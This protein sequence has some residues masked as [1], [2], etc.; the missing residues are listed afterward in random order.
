[1]TGVVDECSLAL[2]AAASSRS[3]MAF[4]V[5]PR[6]RSSSWAAG[7]EGAARIRWRRSPSRAGAS[8]P[9]AQRRPHG[10]VRASEA[11]RSAIGPADQEQRGQAREGVVASGER[12]ADDDD[13]PMA[14]E[15]DRSGQQANRL[16][17]EARCPR[18]G[19]EFRPP[20]AA[21]TS[22]WRG[23]AS[24]GCCGLGV[25]E[26]PVGVE[27]LGEAGAAGRQGA[28]DGLAES[29]LAGANRRDQRIAAGLEVLVDRVVEVVLQAQVGGRGPWRRAPSP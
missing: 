25:E 11:S 19:D 28:S 7:P 9:R 18:A 27:H 22:G 13:Q 24:A 17:L 26:A 2:A 12:G 5:S 21:A 4:R 8:P 16:P 23:P 15:V 10:P 1:M 3:S 29:K 14:L 6:R 20:W